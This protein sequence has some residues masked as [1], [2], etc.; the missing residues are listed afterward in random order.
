MNDDLL[1]KHE[2]LL[3]ELAK[4]TEL[5][6]ARN[7]KSARSMEASAQTLGKNAQQLTDSGERLAGDALDTIRAQGG[8]AFL[9]GTGPALDS[10]QRQIQST[11][12]LVGK[13]DQALVEHRHGIHG[14]IRN[15]LIVL[16]FGALA[17][18]GVAVYMA[19]HAHQEMTRSEW[20]GQI[21]AAIASGKL[22][23]CPDGGL[24]AYIG[25]KLVRLDQ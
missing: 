1:H 22:V 14:L 8:Q 25:K 21:N 19:M 6:N 3:T 16:A 15:A 7:E 5:I 18:I 17:V 24:C 12:G 13:L 2:K 10:L 20:I 23:A 4:V 11:L 9:E